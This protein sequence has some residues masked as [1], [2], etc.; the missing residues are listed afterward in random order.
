[1]W[2]TDSVRHTEQLGIRP[3]AIRRPCDRATTGSA[4]IRV[5]AGELLIVTGPPG[6][7]KSTAAA[8]LVEHR[9][10]SVLVEGDDFF[11]FLR[12][13]RIEPWL[14][15]SQVQNEVVTE[16]AGAA[17]G[18]FAAGGYWTVYDGVV[19]PW[20]LARFVAATGLARV[21]YVVL[22]PSVDTCVDRVATRLG[23]GFT[24]EPATRQM[25]DAFAS[26]VLPD[27]HVIREAAAS[28]SALV[29][30]IVERVE[31]GRCAYPR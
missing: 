21:H 15:A 16:A 23:H 20:F 3:D 30:T 11:R 4:N 17:T 14:A 1:V 12:R 10:P 24:D 25:H 18:R 31:S 5:V 28:T 26:A 27:G 19:G 8:L 2:R 22:L 9:E 29:E 7:G 6:A 13:G